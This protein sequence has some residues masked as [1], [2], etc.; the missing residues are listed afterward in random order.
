[1]VSIL[2]DHWS[3]CLGLMGIGIQEHMDNHGFHSHILDLGEEEQPKSS[4]LVQ[5]KLRPYSCYAFK[6]TGHYFKKSWLHPNNFGAQIYL[7]VLRVVSGSL[8]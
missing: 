7:R 8:F 3:C 1:M 4:L 5:C 2:P 6:A